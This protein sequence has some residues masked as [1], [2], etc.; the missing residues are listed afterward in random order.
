MGRRLEGAKVTRPEQAALT[1]D[2][3]ARPFRLRYS[4]RTALGTLIVS[5]TLALSGVRQSHA[6]TATP[7]SDDASAT[8]G[9]VKLLPRDVILPVAAVQ[10][11]IPEIAEET[12]T[13]AN[14][15][16]M[17][18]PIANRAVTYSTADG[19]HHLVLSVDEYRSA[20]DAARE[21]NEAVEASQEVPG[22][23]TEM[24]SN[25][26]EA[27]L[28]GVVTQGDE[29]HVGGGALFGNLVVGATLQSFDGTAENKARVAELLRK[30][31]EHAF[32]VLGLA[33]PATPSG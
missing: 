13:G 10:A 11:V 20:E 22:V 25:L 32:G 2:S 19:A 16:A 28:L 6:K 1:L 24:V 4:R 7:E 26:G 31:A 18:T 5:S 3:V 15:S 14:A 30:Q 8:R 12:N 23:A 17:G 33:A 27:A 21:F 9:P 29:T